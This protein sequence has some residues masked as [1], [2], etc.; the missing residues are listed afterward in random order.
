[1]KVCPASTTPTFGYRIAAK[2]Y[3]IAYEP[4]AKCYHFNRPTLRA[5]WRQ[6]LQYGKNTL[7]LYFKHG[8]LA[9][10]DEITDW[11][12]NLMPLM[13]LAL[14]ASFLVGIVPLLRPLWYVTAAIFVLMLIYFGV[15]AAKIAAKYHDAQSWRLVVLYFVRS[16]AWFAG[17]TITTLQLLFRRNKP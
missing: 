4:T 16:I 3:K 13:V 2:G 15:L 8:S 9:R 6:Q 12:M 1:M 5:Y 10:G 7:K 11:G 17:A 14:F